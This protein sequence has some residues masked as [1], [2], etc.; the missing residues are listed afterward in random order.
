MVPKSCQKDVKKLTKVNQ[1]L[2][3]SDNLVQCVAL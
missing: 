2:Y 3:E 1:E